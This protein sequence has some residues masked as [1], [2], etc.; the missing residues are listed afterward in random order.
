[1]DGP[2]CTQS[3]KRACR[4]NLEIEKKRAGKGCTIDKSRVRNEHGMLSV[5]LCYDFPLPA[6]FRYVVRVGLKLVG[7]AWLLGR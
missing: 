5:F 1:M 6:M 4:Q 7:L 2:V 3:K